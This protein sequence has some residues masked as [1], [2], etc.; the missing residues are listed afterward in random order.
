M[1]YSCD[2]ILLRWYF[3]SFLCSQMYFLRI[4]IIYLYLSITLSV[5]R[6]FPPSGLPSEFHT[7]LSMLF[8]RPQSM[9]HTLLYICSS[10][11]NFSPYFS[12]Q[13]SATIPNEELSPSPMK[14]IYF[15]TFL[16]SIDRENHFLPPVWFHFIGWSFMIYLIIIFKLWNCLILGERWV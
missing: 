5:I 9:T 7:S 4:A 11:N 6:S 12:L 2:K 14:V 13:A 3:A 15:M 8:N 10:H 16:K 1:N